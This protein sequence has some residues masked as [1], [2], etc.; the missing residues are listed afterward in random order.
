EPDEPIPFRDLP[1]GDREEAFSVLFRKVRD[2]DALRPS[3]LANVRFRLLRRRA[4]GSGRRGRE[5]ILVLAALLSGVGVA[6]GGWG[7]IEWSRGSAREGL[8]APSSAPRAPG[9]ARAASGGRGATRPSA[10]APSE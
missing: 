2:P 6:F 3:E 10:S 1:A 9:P 4:R 5:A 8:A 7:V